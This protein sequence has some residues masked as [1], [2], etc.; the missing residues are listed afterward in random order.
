MQAALIFRAFMASP[1]DVQEERD[2]ACR[3]ITDWNA[4]HSLDRDAIIEPVRLETHA[5]LAQGSHPQEQINKQL[6]DR[7][8]FLIAV[9]WS[10]LGSPTN[11][12]KSGSIHEIKEFAKRKGAECFALFL[13]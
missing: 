8:D 6:L 10:R 4:V 5:Q 9:F 1:G 2:Q 7:C 12:E 13:R 11:T 3:V